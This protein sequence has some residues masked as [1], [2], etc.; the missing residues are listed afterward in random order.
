MTTRPTV[1]IDEWRH[2]PATVLRLAGRLDSR[3]A[4]ALEARLAGI[5]A[6][7][8]AVIDLASVEYITGTCLR[9]LV[10]AAKRMDASGRQLALCAPQDP[11]LDVL[12][13]S[14]LTRMLHVH[15]DRAAALAEI[16][17]LGENG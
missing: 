2:G 3:A 15:A 6:A 13:I 17:H 9:L 16:D 11:V 1:M 14:G 5:E 10:L 4:P 8:A 7:P 12:R